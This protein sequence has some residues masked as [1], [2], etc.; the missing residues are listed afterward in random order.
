MRAALMAAVAVAGLLGGAARASGPALHLDSVVVV[1]RH[2]VR[3]PTSAQPVPVEVSPEPWPQWSVPPGW[4]TPHG[5][6]EVSALA[7]EDRALLIREGLLP[8]RG[9]PAPGHVRIVADG[10]D[11]RTVAT[12][13]AYADGLAHGCA[14]TQDHAP[15]IGQPDPLYSPLSAGR[16]ALDPARADAAAAA[17]LNEP[18]TRA[19]IARAG[20]L[21]ARLNAIL[22][23]QRKS[24]CGFDTKAPVTLRPAT[25]KKGP[26]LS[27]APGAGSSAAQSLL[28]EYADGKPMAQVGWGRA[29]AADITALSALHALKFRITERPPIWR[30][31]RCRGWRLW[32]GRPWA[33][34]VSCWCWA[35]MTA[36]WPL[37]AA[38]WVCTGR[39]RV[40]RPT[41]FRPAARC[42][43]KR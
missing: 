32:S 43:S 9:C 25:V 14:V 15:V 4:L 39:R 1:M 42:C 10:G 28:L 33:S 26:S 16:V 3:P 11:Q 7:R 40:S 34:S 2:G 36:R 8:A 6:Q 38:C 23:G 30:A 31:R 29:T 18:D 20:P 35:A 37:S 17:V 41:I 27:G 5:A 22:C 19:Q 13:A 24:G 21:V 12:G